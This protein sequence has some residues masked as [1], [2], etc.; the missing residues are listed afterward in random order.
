[1]SL[2]HI[3]LLYCYNRYLYHLTVT[4]IPYMFYCLDKTCQ[5]NWSIFW[6]HLY[7]NIIKYIQMDPYRLQ[8]KQ[9]R[10]KYM[11]LVTVL[12][13]LSSIFNDYISPKLKWTLCFLFYQLPMK[14]GQVFQSYTLDFCSPK[15]VFPISVEIGTGVLDKN[16]Q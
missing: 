5:A 10:L 9:G 1:M 8:I 3:A 6:S 13:C 11:T 14:M 2:F 4:M 15:D 16:S 7:N 12:S